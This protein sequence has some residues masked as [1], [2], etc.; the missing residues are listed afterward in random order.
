MFQAIYCIVILQHPI[1]A[2]DDLMPFGLSRG[3]S[4]QAKYSTCSTFI[5]DFPNSGT[6]SE[7]KVGDA[8]RFNN[9]LCSFLEPI[10]AN[11]LNVTE[12]FF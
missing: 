4:L 10:M 2:L 9:T 5:N 12:Q 1:A 6:K 8:N 3:C 11:R 7:R